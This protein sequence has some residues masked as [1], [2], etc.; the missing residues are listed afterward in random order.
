[1]LAALLSVLLTVA[2]IEV[3]LRIYVNLSDELV[4]EASGPRALQN[5]PESSRVYGL[6]GSLGPPLSTNSFGFRGPEIQVSNI[7]KAFRIVMLGDSITFGN[8]VEW[9]E[10]FSYVLEE[11]LNR[12]Y[13]GDRFQVLNLGVSG[14]NTQQELATLRELGMQFA[15]D[16]I[17]LNVCL[18]DSDPAK[19]VF[20][21]GLINRTTV[22][23][24]SD[25]NIRT[26]VA[27]SYFLTF[28]KENLFRLLERHGDFVSKFNSPKL[29]LDSRVR[30]TAWA[31]MKQHMLGIA[32]LAEQ[33]RI[34]LLVIIYPY[35]SQVGLEGQERLPQQDLVRFLS[36]LDIPVLDAAPAY[37]NEG[38][39]MFVDGYIHLSPEGHRVIADVIREFMIN[40]GILLPREH[41]GNR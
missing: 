32:R 35:A 4:A 20:K 19:D 30:E 8:S 25:L 27:S 34:P 9:Y 38:Q 13:G 33:A 11:R 18:N 29:F 1:M 2:V 36:S 5:F 15:P 6:T 39:A 21:V 26:V 22:S 28:V 40:E 14:Y 17:V 16:L 23:R 31:N 37:R 12:E 24:L 10:T 7:T 3:G 41:V